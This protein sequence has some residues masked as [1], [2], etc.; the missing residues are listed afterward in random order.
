MARDHPKKALSSSKNE[1][2]ND[3]SLSTR[4]SETAL[5]SPSDKCAI[6]ITR[7][8]RFAGKMNGESWYR[9][10]YKE[11]KSLA[12]A[13]DSQ[14]REFYEAV[15]KNAS[16]ILSAC[17]PHEACNMRTRIREIFGK[18]PHSEI[19]KLRR[20]YEEKVTAPIKESI[21]TFSFHTTMNYLNM[22]MFMKVRF[23]LIS[24]VSYLLFLFYSLSR[25]TS[26]LQ[27]KR[28]ERRLID[29][30]RNLVDKSCKTRKLIKDLET[31]TKAVEA[32]ASLIMEK[33]D[34][35]IIE[36]EAIIKEYE[37]KLN[38]KNEHITELEKNLGGCR[39]YAS[40]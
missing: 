37:E 10:E 33:K 24:F 17:L 5:L 15:E 16:N 39:E 7:F 34:K 28:E 14:V 4:K 31:K 30:I 19:S 29:R 38:N 2:N 21:E 20:E 32:E 25:Q 36:L 27:Q 8:I 22:E 6:R 18:S 11:R 13:K 23:S 9:R 1:S 35:R 12:E 40:C 26:L 3:D